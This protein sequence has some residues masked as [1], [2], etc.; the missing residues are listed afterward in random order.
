MWT[1]QNDGKPGTP[2]EWYVAYH[3]R[4]GDLVVRVDCACEAGARR[5]FSI[6]QNTTLRIQDEWVP[7]WGTL[8]IPQPQNPLKA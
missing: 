4:N 1:V 2:I 6:V 3:S 5:V 7:G 8:K